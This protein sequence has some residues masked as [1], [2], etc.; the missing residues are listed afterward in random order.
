MLRPVFYSVPLQGQCEKLQWL[1]N[2]YNYTGNMLDM[3]EFEILYSLRERHNQVPVI[4][5]G[6][7][8]GTENMTDAGVIC[9][10]SREQRETRLKQCLAFLQQQKKREYVT[11]FSGPE[12]IKVEA[13]DK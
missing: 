1:I 5:I 9:T 7:V 11:G 13:I 2:Y 12:T 6:F 10:T 3:A 8:D 4:S